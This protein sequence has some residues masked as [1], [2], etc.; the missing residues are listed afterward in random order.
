MKTTTTPAAFPADLARVVAGYDASLTEHADHWLV[1]LPGAT[2][3]ASWD[4]A[5]IVAGVLGGHV[6]STT[7]IRIA[8]I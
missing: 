6:E 1:T 2:W 5:K 7:Q 3:S 8:K 4:R